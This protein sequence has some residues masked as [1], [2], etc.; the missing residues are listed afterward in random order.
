MLKIRSLAY[1][2]LTG[3]IVDAKLTNDDNVFSSSK[4]IILS[5]HSYYDVMEQNYPVIL[6][7]KKKQIGEAVS[8]QLE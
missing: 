6:S 7:E 3:F 5:S 1:K 8:Q 2:Y 4:N